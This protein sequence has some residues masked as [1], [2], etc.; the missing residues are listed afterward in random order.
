MNNQSSVF[1]QTDSHRNLIDQV[2]RLSQKSQWHNIHLKPLVHSVSK[3]SFISFLVASTSVFGLNSVL[4]Q[5]AIEEGNVTIT[6]SPSS[7]SSGTL[8]G[9]TITGDKT[10]VGELTGFIDTAEGVN[11]TTWI[12]LN[13][14]A[15]GENNNELT[16]NVSGQLPVADSKNKVYPDDAYYRFYMAAAFNTVATRDKDLKALLGGTVTA[17]DSADD[18]SYISEGGNTYYLAGDPNDPS[19]FFTGSANGY[20]LNIVLEKEASISTKIYGARNDLY[21]IN[22]GDPIGAANNNKVEITFN[23]GSTLYS[24]II[25]GGRSAQAE[26]KAAYIGYETN[27]NQ[28]ILNGFTQK[29][30]NGSL[31]AAAPAEMIM[32]A[33]IWGAEGWE[34]NYNYVQIQDA[35]I[36]AQEA[37]NAH[38]GIVG[39]RGFFQHRMNF[40]PKRDGESSIAN[41]NIVVIKNSLIGYENSYYS[42]STS[43]NKNTLEQKGETP[44]SVFGGYSIGSAKDNLVVLDNVQIK[45]NVY[46]GLEL[47][48][49]AKGSLDSIRELNPNMV[50]LH[51][52]TLAEGHS[53]YGTATADLYN[54]LKGSDEKI[55]NVD[56]GLGWLEPEQGKIDEAMLLPVNRRRGVAYLAGKVESDS[57][58]VR[59]IHFGQYYDADAV[60]AGQ[61]ITVTKPYYPHVDGQASS[62]KND[63][64]GIIRITDKSAPDLIEKEGIAL[65]QQVAKSYLLDRTGFHSDLSPKA[66]ESDTTQGLH[67]FW[68]GA[69]V[70]LLGKVKGD[71]KSLDTT[72]NLFK[73]GEVQHGY[74]QDSLALTALDDGY[75]F[76]TDKDTPLMDQFRDNYT[77]ETGRVL[78]LAVNSGTNGEEQIKAVNINFKEIE[79]YRNVIT[80]QGTKAHG[81]TLVGV[82]VNGNGV[83]DEEGNVSPYAKDPQGNR[84][85]STNW[86]SFVIHVPGFEIIQTDENNPEAYATFGIYKYLHFDG[87]Y[88]PETGIKQTAEGEAGGVGLKYWLESLNLQDGKNLVLYGKGLDETVENAE[89]YTLSAYLTGA[90]GITIPENNVVIVGNTNQPDVAKVISGDGGVVQETEGVN[91]FTGSTIIGKSAQLIQGSNGALG[92]ETLYTSKL[93]LESGTEE[94]LTAYKLRGHTQTVGGLVVDK[95]AVIYFNDK[96][97]SGDSTE[98]SAAAANADAAGE[99]TVKGYAEVRGSLIDSEN[100]SD[101]EVSS[102]IPTLI[103]DRGTLH[104]YSDNA[105]FTGLVDLKTSNAQ[106]FSTNALVNATARVGAGSSLYFDIQKNT[107]AQASAL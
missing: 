2:L 68:V 31:N 104:I 81:N 44:I 22:S 55:P 58:Y 30:N 94:N 37:T 48:N 97:S 25:F 20:T 92:S 98:S 71:G 60:Q 95:N 23:E 42:W 102:A 96:A 79:E 8:N 73:D 53:F 107:A 16:I 101:V 52:V 82:W 87:E 38:W 3:F 100:Q 21:G 50:S 47:Q 61:E 18:P 34:T 39:G 91:T 72:V 10:D 7:N 99:L 56:T 62:E 66:G 13:K 90:G 12:Y 63:E 41:K 70:N 24:Q 51:N 57:A 83:V 93:S 14:E 67:N 26:G 89:T 29:N 46:G 86:D 59:Y 27:Y 103:M 106:L 74:S 64:T 1:H 36:V 80:N 49:T 84:A 88:D 40:D 77:N 76:S 19:T 105:G 32:R 75:V 65:G 4:A 15:S 5:E 69:Y 6:L 9:F 11:T 43:D 85:T 17:G 78:Y 35:T 33:G 54:G 45:G 28:V